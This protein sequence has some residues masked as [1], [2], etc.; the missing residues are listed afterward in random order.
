MWIVL[1]HFRLTPR[2]IFFFALTEAVGAA[3]LPF[4][5]PDLPDLVLA[6]FFFM[7]RTRRLFMVFIL[8][9]LLVGEG[10]GARV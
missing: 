8:I 3:V 7:R 5:F 6:V 9:M 4:P 1:V 2:T 10:V